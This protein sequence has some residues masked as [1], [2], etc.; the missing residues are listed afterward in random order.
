M[1]TIVDPYNGVWKICDQQ[2]IIKE[3]NEKHFG[4]MDDD[5]G[6]EIYKTLMPKLYTGWF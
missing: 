3:Q 4:P 6:S 2:I 1:W 5:H